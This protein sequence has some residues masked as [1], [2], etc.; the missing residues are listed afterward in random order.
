M[1]H[2]L[3]GLPD[4]EH[5]HLHSR[6]WRK[7]QSRQHQCSVLCA[8]PVTQDF[9]QTQGMKTWDL[10]PEPPLAHSAPLAEFARRDCLLAGLRR[11]SKG[12]V[13]RAERR[14]Q[15]LMR[16]LVRL[17]E[18][19]PPDLCYIHQGRSGKHRLLHYL[20]RQYGIPTLH[21]GAGLLPNT[22]QWD[23]TGIDGDASFA[24]HGSRQYRQQQADGDFLSATLAAWLARSYPPPLARISTRLPSMGQQMLTMLRCLWRQQGPQAWSALHAWTRAHPVNYPRLD[25]QPLLPDLPFLCVLLQDPSATRR[26]LDAP[27]VDNLQLIRTCHQA[28]SE[29]DPGAY[30]V[31]VLPELGLAKK[32]IHRLQQEHGNLIFLS[33]SAAATAVSTA[34]AVVTVNHPLGLAAILSGTPVIHLGQSPYGIPGISQQSHLQQLS[35]DLPQALTASPSNIRERFL[36]RMLR[37]QHLWCSPLAPDS[38]GLAGLVQRLEREMQAPASQP[39]KYRPG[40]VWPLAA[41]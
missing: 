11:P 8:D 41:D 2:V 30:V 22:M 39:L 7:M 1:G 32:A 12:Q 18:E 3:C 23:G 28:L 10:K 6:L 16:P 24:S 33:A 9:Y 34:M 37:Q 31:V 35:Q 4:I 17:L 27:A 19:Q 26:L 15:R 38:N 40:P 13:R 29:L 36:T 14:L 5:F 21:T 20:A 25:D